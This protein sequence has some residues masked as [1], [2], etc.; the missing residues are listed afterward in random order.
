VFSLKQIIAVVE[1]AV[2]AVK[3][4]IEERAPRKISGIATKAHREQ[5]ESEIKGLV[6]GRRLHVY[7]EVEL[8]GVEIVHLEVPEERPKQGFVA[9]VN[10][11][12]KDYLRDEKSGEVLR[13]DKKTYS[14]Q[15]FWCFKRSQ[16]RWLLKRI[17]PSADMDFIIIPKN[18][19]NPKALKKFAREADEEYLREFTDG[20]PTNN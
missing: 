18:L 1:R 16:D 6:K 9:L 19:L 11:R 12:S 8:L 17:R 10:L 5:L 13:G 3:T 14:Y 2:G 4:A 15:E 7:G 20:Q